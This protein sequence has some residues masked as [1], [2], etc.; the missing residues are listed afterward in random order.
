MV[1][2]SLKISIL[3]FLREHQALAEPLVFVLGFAEGIPLLSFFVPSSALFLAIGSAQGA[4]GGSVWGLWASAAVGAMLGDCV[5]YAA[6]RR[7]K[8]RAQ[9]M[10]PLSRH[11]DRIAKGYALFER[12]GVL[13][14]FAGKFLGFMR[15]IIPV[16][17][18]VLEMPFLLFLLANAV[19]SALWAGAFLLPGW[20]M[21]SFLG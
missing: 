11:P 12:W 21:I 8:H 10:W 9:Q 1:S 3:S 2:E 18:G 19:S 5:T 6:G 7:F 13:A 17:A 14:V 16:I 20:G 15:P 4:L